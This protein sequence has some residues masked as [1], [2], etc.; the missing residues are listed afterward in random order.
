VTT[1]PSPLRKIIPPLVWPAGLLLL[2]G[3]CWVGGRAGRPD[4]IT[5]ERMAASR[6]AAIESGRVESVSAVALEAPLA[7]AIPI[8]LIAGLAVV[9]GIVIW[10]VTLRS[11]KA[12]DPATGRE[13]RDAP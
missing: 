11:S 2:V 6:A 13:D 1:T 10:G 7:F 3:Y 9:V 8:P 4:A 5:A 12:P